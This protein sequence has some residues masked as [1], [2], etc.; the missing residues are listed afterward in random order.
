[1][2][3]KKPK[4]QVVFFKR[5]DDSKGPRVPALEFFNSIPENALATLDAVAERSTRLNHQ[6]EGSATGLPVRSWLATVAIG[7]FFSGCAGAVNEQAPSMTSQQS[8]P[9]VASTTTTPPTT[10]AQPTT[11]ILPPT[12]TTLA[13]TDLPDYTVVA[14]EDV[15]FPGAVRISL[16][17][18]VETGTD[19][20]QLRA[21]ASKLAEQYRLSHEYQAF[22]IFFYHYPELAFD[23]ATLG[24]WEDAPFGDW[25]RADEV[26]RGDYS[27]HQPFDD[28]KEKDWSL[29][30]TQGEVD[31]YLAYLTTYDEM[32]T[33]DD[34]PSDD[35]VFAMVA[36]DYGVSPMDVENA[37]DAVL[38]WMFNG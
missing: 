30:P 16:R 32:D 18:A 4:W 14:E 1:M 10:T 20:D 5:V 13:E 34:L 38:D 35:D 23:S 7:L 21:L 22:N 12:T 8:A 33:G 9:S 37:A 19:A 36:T 29:L 6:N 24:R 28:L 26:E 27:K 3:T 15:S 31:L 17:V 25:G 11:T 2:A